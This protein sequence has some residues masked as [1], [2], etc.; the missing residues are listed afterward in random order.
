MPK[1]TRIKGTQ[2]LYGE[3]I[4]Y[5]KYVE[6][7]AEEVLHKYSFKE[8]RTPILENTNLILRGVGETTDVV[9]KEM[10]TFEDK[11]KRSVTMR[12]E[13][14]APVVRAYVENSMSQMGSPIKLYYNGPMF[15]YE[16]PQKGRL[17]Q[18]HQI[19]A[20]I[21]G[22][23]SALADAELIEMVYRFLKELGLKEFKIKVN[24]IGCD[25]CRA[26]YHNALK[27][28]YAK[29]LD[30]MCDDCK[31]RFDTN[32]MR[33]IDC[34]KDSEYAKQAPSILN[35]LDDDCKTHF[36]KLKSYLDIFDIPYEIDDRIV[37]GLD[38]YTKTAFEIEH[39]LL[40]AQS[41]IGGGGRYDKM[42]KEIG[43][44]STPSVG[45]AFGIERLVLALKEEN[46]DIPE[47]EEID[48][49]VI[50]NGEN[51]E[52]EAINIAK[53]LRK[54][55]IKVF[56]NVS[57]RNFGGQM[58]HANKVNSKFAVIIGEDEVTKNIVTYKDLRTGEQ[59]QVER[60]WFIKLIVEKIKE[61]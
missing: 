42:V 61:N 4:K 30:N 55:D 47:F 2:D 11:G 3:E 52:R 14:T 27:D 24:S 37:R 35:Y 44:P 7:I 17:R 51:A 45:M 53:L 60:D 41:A 32:I 40:G 56:L 31:R 5:F 34:K 19:G 48:V 15:R 59:T 46:V 26:N 33:L 12:P 22:T 54:K 25:T 10:Y 16:K 6:K 28:Y 13:G 43:G 18:F 58:K 21:F 50:Y 23:N 29:H 1:Y 57:N 8:L 49:Y 9:Q 39:P 38:Y 20:E 36:E